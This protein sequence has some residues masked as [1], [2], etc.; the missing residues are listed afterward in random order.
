MVEQ[1]LNN[2]NIEEFKISEEVDLLLSCC[3][4]NDEDPEQY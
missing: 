4:C 3:G 2:L 1:L